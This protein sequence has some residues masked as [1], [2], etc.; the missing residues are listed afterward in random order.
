MFLS[1]FFFFAVNIKAVADHILGGPGLSL[2]C[3]ESHDTALQLVHGFIEEED[4]AQVTQEV[5][6]SLRFHPG[7]C[8]LKPAFLPPS[9]TVPHF[10][11]RP[12]ELRTPRLTI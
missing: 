12:W 11:R 3:S 8:D 1:F 6:A 4:E 7:L 5:R 2:E 10:C 9:P